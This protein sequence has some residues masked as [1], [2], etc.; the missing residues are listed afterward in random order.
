[1]RAWGEGMYPRA[2][3]TA[4]EPARA[5][6]ASQGKI[7][8]DN[9][10]GDQSDDRNDDREHRPMVAAPLCRSVEPLDGQRIVG[11]PM[12]ENSRD[13]RHDGNSSHIP[14]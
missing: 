12:A 6:F 5:T 7:V 14:V 4:H 13:E 10:A 3:V 9:A 11:A 2:H 1:M 8:I